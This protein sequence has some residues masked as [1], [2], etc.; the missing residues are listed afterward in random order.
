MTYRMT[1]HDLRVLR[2]KRKNTKNASKLEVAASSRNK[3][4]LK[5]VKTRLPQENRYAK[6]LAVLAKNPH[7]RSGYKNGKKVGNANHEHWEQVELFNWIYETKPDNFLDFYAVANGGIRPGFSGASLKDEGVTSGQPD[8][9]CDL[10]RGAYYGLRIEMKWGNNKPSPEQKLIM[11]RRTENGY[12]CALCYS[13]VEAAEVVSEYL[14]LEKDEEMVW[15][16]NEDAWVF[17]K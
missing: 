13:S 16:K 9:N 3:P 4:T 14:L 8:V 12:F 17:K 7:L 11:N 15:S 10:P 5:L 6:A 1:E 2:D